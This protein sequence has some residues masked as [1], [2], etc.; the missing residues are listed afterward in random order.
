MRVA[1][2]RS[3]DPRMASRASRVDPDPKMLDFPADA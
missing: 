3:L 1:H 2:A